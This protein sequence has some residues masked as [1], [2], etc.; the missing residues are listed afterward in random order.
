M[1]DIRSTSRLTSEQK[2]DLYRDGFVV[3]RN[4]VSKG[5]VQ[6]ALECIRTAEKGHYVGA[7]QAMTDLVNASTITPILNEVMGTFDPPTTC[8]VGIRRIAEPGEHFINIGYREKDLPYFGAELHMDGLCTMAAPQEVQ[9]GTADEIYHRFFASGPKGDLGRSPDV[10]GHNMMPMFLDPDMTLGLGSFTCFLFVCL[11]DQTVAGRGQTAVLA[12]AH[13]ATE[14]FFRKQRDH[15]NCLGPEG[16]G[17]PRMNH[18]V[19]NRSGLV[20][21]PDE[22]REQYLD[23]DSETTPDGV[24]WPK[25]NLLL[26][27]AGDAAIAVHGIPHCG[28]RNELGTESRKNMIFRIRNKA[29]QPDKVVNGA[30]DHPDR[31]QRGEWLEFEQ[32]NDPWERSKYALCNQ[33]QAWGGMKDV[34]AEQLGRDPGRPLP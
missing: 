25:P 15:N 11:N 22:I 2:R 24:R 12:G 1:S 4:A 21:L 13:H 5:L 10:I 8:Q 34:V 28:T 31:G 29:Q 20:Y 27:D 7:D 18:D 17:W 6:D 3:M 16:I 23:E 32:G 9:D 14:Q 19:P 33:W 26:M 30:S